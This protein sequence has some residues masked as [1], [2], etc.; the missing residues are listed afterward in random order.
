MG[1]SDGARVG[2]CDG[3]IDGARAGVSDGARVG[4][5][6]GVIEGSQV[7]VGLSIG[8]EETGLDDGF[9]C[10]GELVGVIVPPNVGIAVGLNDRS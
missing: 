1:V 4:R 2:R 6:D 10:I 7:G 9:H 3:L 5:H 8:G